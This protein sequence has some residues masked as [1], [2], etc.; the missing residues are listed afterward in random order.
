MLTSFPGKSRAKWPTLRTADG[1][2]S[3]HKAD[4]SDNKVQLS[5]QLTESNLQTCEKSRLNLD[6]PGLRSGRNPSSEE[7]REKLHGA[8]AYFLRRNL[9]TFMAASS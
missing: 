2:V 1:S 4:P 9:N 6:D 5:Q 3:L 7:P 8:L